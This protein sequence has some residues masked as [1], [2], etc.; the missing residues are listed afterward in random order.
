MTT[1]HLLKLASVL[2]FARGC[3]A[4]DAGWKPLFNGKD[5]NGWETRGEC[6][7][8][9]LPDGVL[10]GQRSHPHPS[11][12]FSTPW[13][14]EQ[15]QFD[16]WLYRQAWL[17]TTQEFGEF[18]LHLEYFIPPQMN[19]G[20]SIRDRSRAHAAIGEADS[21]RPDLAKFPKTTPAHIG[22]EIQIIDQ[23]AK[24]PSGSIY[25]FVSAKTEVQRHGEWNSM[26]IESRNDMI[27]VRI[28]GQVVAEGPGDPA[29]SKT[30]PI[31]LQ[32]HDQLTFAM[33]R[34]IRILEIGAKQP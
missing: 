30:G 16:T 3:F 21:D 22:Y 6:L 18:D 9:V 29:R 17:Y 8:T 24:Y 11:A 20:I 12:P 14:V 33:F 19:S 2:L 7:W 27:R 15:K 1:V 13:P 10:L 34:N 31:G 25:T 5:L 26:D 32:L 23:D 4:A 28:N